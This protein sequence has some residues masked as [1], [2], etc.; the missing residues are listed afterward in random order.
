MDMGVPWAVVSEAKVADATSDRATASVL[1]DGGRIRHFSERRGSLAYPC[2]TRVQ[3]HC[4]SFRRSEHF[5]RGGLGRSPCF[6]S[7]EVSSSLGRAGT[8]PAAQ[9][10]GPSDLGTGRT[11]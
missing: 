3:T 1:R 4:P 11:S 2:L 7:V 6:A 9:R 8:P 10:H 5:P